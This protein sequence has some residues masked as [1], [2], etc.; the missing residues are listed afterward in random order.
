VPRSTGFPAAD[1]EDDFSQARR[2]QILARMAQRLRRVPD[3][4]GVIL[5]FDE[6]TAALGRTGERDLGFQVISLDSVV[7]TIDRSRDF[8]RQ[9]RPTSGRVRE[10]WQRIATA[11]RRGEP[12]P[13]IDVYR[14]GDLHFVRDGHH[15]VSVARALGRRSIEAHVVEV[16]TRLPATGVRSRGDLV[17]K[18]YQ[19]LF[20]ERVPLPPEAAAAITVDDPWSWAEL[21]E[22]VEAWGFRLIQQ[23]RRYLTRAEVAQRW[24]DDEYRRVVRMVR[25]A[26]L[27]GRRSQAEAYLQVARERY[28]LIRTHEWSEDIVNRLRSTIR[29]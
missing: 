14:L 13:P 17:V 27:I 6:A 8:D 21:S 19:R 7:G 5:P 9:F 18:D 29:V 22:T 24:Y 16:T 3:D 25:A 23:E 1:A 15:R 10:R 11:E 26:G 2:R 20:L 12:I 4:I 28:R